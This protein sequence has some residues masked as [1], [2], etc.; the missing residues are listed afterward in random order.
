M[1]KEADRLRTYDRWPVS[2][3][4]TN[5]LAAAGFSFI[6]SEDMVR[7]PFCGMQVGRWEPGDDPFREHKCWSQSCG[8]VNGH[9]VINIP[10]GSD[11]HQGVI[12]NIKT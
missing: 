12:V 4:N 8:F 9:F 11:D 10:T 3:V 1:K 5:E 2:F 6:G 7:C